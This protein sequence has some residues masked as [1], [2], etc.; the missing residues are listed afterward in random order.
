MKLG[1]ET[2]IAKAEPKA[3]GGSRGVSILSILRGLIISGPDT[4]TTLVEEKPCEK[5]AVE[6]DND[7]D[8]EAKLR[9]KVQQ[10]ARDAL[11]QAP[12][13]AATQAI[14]LAQREVPGAKGN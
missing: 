14:R 13:R 10:I 2:P 11:N 1:N 12:G 5:A 4:Q 7:G 3:G 8:L 9:L 6:T